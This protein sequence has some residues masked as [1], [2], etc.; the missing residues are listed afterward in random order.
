MNTLLILREDVGMTEDT[1]GP[2]I[3]QLKGKIVQH[4]IQHVEPVKITSVTKTIL[5]KYQEVTIFWDLMHINGIGL[6]NTTS[7]RI[8]FA[9]GSMVKN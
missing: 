3:S 1:Y 4:N 6:L 7:R 2:S 9:T 5:C 8:M